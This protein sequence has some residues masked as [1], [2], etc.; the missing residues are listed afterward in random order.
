MCDIPGCHFW[1]DGGGCE[2]ET[3]CRTGGSRSPEGTGATIVCQCR[4]LLNR[5]QMLQPHAHQVLL[6]FMRQIQQECVA[7]V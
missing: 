6:S 1:L 4:D 2:Q 3:A 5:L 7:E